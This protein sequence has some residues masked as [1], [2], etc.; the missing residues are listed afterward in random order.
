MKD[1][2]THLGKSVCFLWIA[3][4]LGC[5]GSTKPPIQSADPDPVNDTVPPQHS[6]ELTA[7]STNRPSQTGEIGTDRDSLQG[8]WVAMEGAKEGTTIPRPGQVLWILFEEDQIQMNIPDGQ[9]VKANYAL[10]LDHSPKQIE[11]TN[12]DKTVA[13]IYTFDGDMLTVAFA[14][15]RPVDFEP[16]DKQGHFVGKFKRGTTALMDGSLPL[17]LLPKAQANPQASPVGTVPVGENLTNDPSLEDAVLGEQ[18]PP[19][20]GKFNAVPKGTYRF[21]VVEGGR[22]GTKSCLIEGDGQYITVPT[23]RVPVASGKRYAARGW[24]KLEGSP[25]SAQVRILYFDASLRYIGENRQG[26]VTSHDQW[27]LVAITD[28]VEDYPNAQYLALAMSVMGKGKAVF[29]DLELLAFNTDNL[30][31][32]F[33]AQYGRTVS[34]QSRVLDRWLGQW[35]SRTTYQPTEAYPRAGTTIGVTNAAK[36]LDNRFVQLYRASEAVDKEALSLITYDEKAAAY[37]LWVF[38]SSGAA[39][40]YT[41]QWD[42]TTSTLTLQIVPPKP[43]VTGTSIARFSDADAVETNLI[44]KDPAGVVARDVTDVM[45]RKSKQA[46]SDIPLAVEASGLS[47]EHQLL[48]QLL[49]NWTQTTTT[50]PAAWTPQK[51]ESTGSHSCTRILNGRFVYQKNLEADGSTHLHFYTYDAERKQYRRRYFNS[52]GTTSE[53]TGTWNSDAKT[54]TWQSNVG[55]GLTNTATSHFVDSDTIQWSAIVK[56]QSGKIFFHVDG[57][58]T[59]AR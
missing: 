25:V 19:G 28:R 13:G 53:A 57:K 24:V 51:K 50:H 18:F 8:I 31:S 15:E 37:R 23:N 29:D 54:M 6:G 10:Q 2:A 44:V 30:P 32:N 39:Y 9:P 14:A 48:D 41:G 46:S 52:T 1:S 35:E 12:P 38:L 4:C 43:G 40:E 33:E 34:Q 21:E 27:Q 36:I 5:T 16:S 42:E 55:N 26:H 3:L 47:S 22:T 7:P 20:W 49:G 45:I 11:L 58:S 59:R 17:A 56:D